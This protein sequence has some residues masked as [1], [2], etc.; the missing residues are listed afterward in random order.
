MSH[1]V[2][3]NPFLDMLS[4]N[5]SK[6][7]GGKKNPFANNPSIT[8]NEFF[9]PLENKNYIEVL[10]HTNKSMQP[11]IDKASKMP[12][13][14][15]VLNTAQSEMR[16][17]FKNISMLKDLASRAT[18][19][20]QTYDSR[21]FLQKDFYGTLKKIDS[22]ADNMKW[23]GLTFPHGN[24]L[25]RINQID[26]QITTEKTTQVEETPT[27]I[28]NGDFDINSD[29]IYKLP[30]DYSGTISVNAQN[31]KIIQENPSTPLTDV[32]IVGPAEGHANLW[33]E[34]VNI[35]NL[36]ER[37]DSVIKFSGEDN[38]LSF[39]GDNSIK[40]GRTGNAV[41]NVG[42]GLTLN[43]SNNDAT[44]NVEMIG[45]G[46]G[47]AASGAGIGSNDS[48]DSTANINING[49]T[50]NVTM[51]SNLDGAAIGS[52]CAYIHSWDGTSH[53]SIGDINVYGGTIN[54]KSGGTTTQGG[55]GIGAGLGAKCGNISIDNAKVTA[56]AV[57]GAAIG[58]GAGNSVAG[59]IR[60][61]GNTEI[62]TESKTGS[63]IGTG[64][65]YYAYDR[66]QFSSVGNI[67]IDSRAKIDTSG[68]GAGR[69]ERQATPGQVR[70]LNYGEVSLNN[71][72]INVEEPTL[73]FTTNTET[74]QKNISFTGTN[75][76][77]PI[78]THHNNNNDIPIIN[79]NLMNM[80]PQFLGTSNL[81]SPQG[82]FLNPFDQQRYDSFFGNSNRQNDWME[83]VMG[84]SNKN[85]RSID[86]MSQ[87]NAAIALRVIE[88]ALEQV[89]REM[90][91]VNNYIQR[92]IMSN[93]IN[94]QANNITNNNNTHNGRFPGNF[95]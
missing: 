18:D 20:M 14:A 40:L 91:N 47:V 60:I 34:G 17:I 7:T 68:I 31:V 93:Q 58:A 16:S 53:G 90:S 74:I 1:N 92:F 78:I 24:S 59:D 39:K 57:S 5:S 79:I 84:A 23:N 26:V 71:P 45:T 95:V 41:I 70:S 65:G 43:G 54:V 30:E 80:H 33:L 86:I 4:H 11:K 21:N 66:N 63:G 50:I 37:G 42:G 94:Q 6:K 49:G 9:N 75:L 64:Y 32:H 56:N 55:A 10:Q 27:I 3:N 72:S 2:N 81:I 28:Q 73:G 88:G 8:N 25:V 22:S 12:T 69:N 46:G 82:R 35:E 36:A 29:G 76:L 48:E 62:H 85:L 13:L 15:D 51:G 89:Q 19:N 44:L 87:R 77:R 67:E 83:I 38:V 52:G 61:G